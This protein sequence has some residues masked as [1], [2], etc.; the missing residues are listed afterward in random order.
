MPLPTAVFPRLHNLH[1][2]DLLNYKAKA[3]RAIM[4]GRGKRASFHTPHTAVHGSKHIMLL[5]PAAALLLDICA[6]GRRHTHSLLLRIC[7]CP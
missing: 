7:R 2:F 1:L 4:G 5:P 6:L 3:T